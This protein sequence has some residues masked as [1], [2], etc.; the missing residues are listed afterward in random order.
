M[1]W[2][3]FVTS[4]TSEDSRAL[5][6]ALQKKYDISNEY[7]ENDYV[8][9]WDKGKQCHGKIITF[10]PFAEN[11][12]TVQSIT[13]SSDIRHL[14]RM[15]LCRCPLREGDK[16]RIL[17]GYDEGHTGTVETVYPNGQVQ[18]LVFGRCF[19]QPES[20]LRKVA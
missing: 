17:Y 16:I 7:I 15:D 6:D 1:N 19:S 2:S 8:D 18:V 9:F 3:L 4:L 14:K 13:L 5:Y 11:P 20:F 10:D 12:Y